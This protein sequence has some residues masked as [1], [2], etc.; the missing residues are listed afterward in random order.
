MIKKLKD[1]AE[2]IVFKHSVFALPFI[3]VAMI[4]AS[5]IENGSAWFGFK[6]LILGTLCAVSARNFAMAFNRYQDEDIDKLNPRTASR[7]SVDG[8]IGKG[9]MQLFI[10]ANALIFI[11]CAYFVNSLAFWLSFPI[12]AV[13]GG[14]SLFKRFSEL[15]HLVLGLSLGLAPIAGVVAVSADIP[16]WS[17]L[18]CLGVTF[19]VAGFDL[20]YSLQDIKFDQE[21]KLFSI[22]A[23]YGDKATLFLSAIFHALAFILWLLFA[24]AAG[25]GAMA[26]FGI[27]V[28]GVILFFEHRIVRRDFSKID[29]AFFTLNGYLGILFF[30]FVWI[31]VL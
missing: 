10:T 11:I 24:W 30:I 28:S 8:R 13:L 12:L 22:P 16:L 3:F 5:K 9:N 31:S 18:L 4:V 1:N 25:L 26:F 29:R 20:L 15:A 2:L 14:Y 6:L 23:I 27:V 17:V 21:N 7:P 19:W